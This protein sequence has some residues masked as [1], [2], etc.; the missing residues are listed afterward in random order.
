MDDRELLTRWSNGDAVAGETLF[1]RHVDAVCR[2]FANK[3]A[4][5]IEDLVQQTFLA[6]L[7]SAPRYRG[8]SA[9]RSWLIGIANNVLRN[10]YAAQHRAPITFATVSIEDLAPS[11]SRMLQ[12]A[13]SHVAL[14]DALR[15][16]PIDL[17]VVLELFFWEDMPGSEIAVT[18]GLPEGTVRSRL[19]RGREL[20]AEMMG[21]EATVTAAG[22]DTRDDLDR[23]SADLRERI[24]RRP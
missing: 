4:N 5:N 24:A 20:L 6:C 15:R 16:V 2:F 11:V 1:E 12:L 13:Q 18:L 3:A 8:E 9:V 19:R 10:H 14:L 17:Q 23:W 21:D 22:R 7:E